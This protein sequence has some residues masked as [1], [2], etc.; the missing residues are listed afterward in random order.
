MT[1]MLA[2]LA[3]VPTNRVVDTFELLQQQVPPELEPIADIWRITT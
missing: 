2:A 1:R 3:F